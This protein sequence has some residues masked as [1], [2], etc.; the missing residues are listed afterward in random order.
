MRK[1]L[2]ILFVL[3]TKVVLSQTAL[4]TSVLNE[5]NSYRKS[6]GLKEVIYNSQISEYCLKHNEYMSSLRRGDTITKCHSNGTM[7]FITVDSVRV[8]IVFGGEVV[9]FS[10]YLC[11]DSCIIKNFKDSPQHNATLKWNPYYVERVFG[12]IKRK[13]FQIYC[14]ISVYEKDEIQYVTIKFS[15][16]K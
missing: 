11:N 1:I 8:N 15:H 13:Y 4:E 14:G 12:M 10:N 16:K 2:I 5:L 3:F 6:L 9:Q 7:D